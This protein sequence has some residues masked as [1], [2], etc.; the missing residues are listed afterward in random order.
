MKPLL[1]FL[2]LGILLTAFLS[3]NAE[4][5]IDKQDYIVLPA[6]PK[7]SNSSY[8]GVISEPYL[9]LYKEKNNK[10]DIVTTACCCE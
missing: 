6:T 7:F 10:E 3:C 9:K 1:T 5:N 2:I 8:W 4:N